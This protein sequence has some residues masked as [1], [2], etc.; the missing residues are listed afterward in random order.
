MIRRR[1]HG[2]T[3]DATL[4]A[5]GKSKKVVLRRVLF[6]P[7]I[8]FTILDCTEC[9]WRV[10]LE[11]HHEYGSGRRTSPGPRSN[12]DVLACPKCKC[13]SWRY[14]RTEV[15]NRGPKSGLFSLVKL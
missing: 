14:I 5:A 15:M 12:R 2:Q 3:Y 1:Q 9:H 4:K 6:L 13:L 7:G 8:A 11:A 10:Y